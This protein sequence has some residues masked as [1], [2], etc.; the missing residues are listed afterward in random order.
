[1]ERLRILLIE[2][3]P[4]LSLLFRRMLGKLDYFVTDVVPTEVSA[5]N[6]AL[7]C[8]PDLVVVDVVIRDSIIGLDLAN[9]VTS[10]LGI[11]GILVSNHSGESLRRRDASIANYHFMRKPFFVEDLATAISHVMSSERNP[12]EQ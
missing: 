1:M 9:A 7:S 2:D 11:P 8:A 5:L 3:D 6:R 4:A 12:N 10:A